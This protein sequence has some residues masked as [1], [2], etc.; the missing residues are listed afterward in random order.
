MVNTCSPN[1]Y[2]HECIIVRG[3]GSL[4]HLAI[5]YMWK[6]R[7]NCSCGI[8]FLVFFF[9]LLLSLSFYHEHYLNLILFAPP[10]PDNYFSGRCAVHSASAVQTHALFLP[11]VSI[12]HGQ[13]LATC[14]RL[15]VGGRMWRSAKI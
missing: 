6:L 8:K 2:M 11:E 4:E 9:F 5:H 14:V 7:T 13:D 12:L 15:L 1:E 10:N 3:E